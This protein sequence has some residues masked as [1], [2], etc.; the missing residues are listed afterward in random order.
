METHG[1]KVVSIY[2]KGYKKHL[3][4]S[5]SEVTTLG[6]FLKGVIK[7]EVLVI[8]T[9]LGVD[10]YYQAIVDHTNLIVDA[11]LL[12]KTCNGQHREEFIIKSLNHQD[13]IV[14]E[15]QRFFLKLIKN[16]LLFRNYSKS[17]T[18]QIKNHYHPSS[19]LINQLLSLW[20]RELIKV[21][22]SIS[23]ETTSHLLPLIMSLTASNI[24]E[25]SQPVV[26]A[27]I[28][29]AMSSRNNN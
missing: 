14:D 29:E 27:L 25:D 2:S 24:E 21:P 11:F 19:K 23:S 15:T 6:A 10:I 12:L 20:K 9:N 8:N 26:E 28:R 4:I 3:L 5:N 18:H 17:L 13:A 16:P 22:Q 1:L 7:D